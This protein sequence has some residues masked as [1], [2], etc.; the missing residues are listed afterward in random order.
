MQQQWFSSCEA[1]QSTD[2]EG[3][4]ANACASKYRH[5]NAAQK[6][7]GAME[8]AELESKLTF[9]FSNG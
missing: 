2:R 7:Y 5:L 9:A 4:Y 3:S 6:A 8:A 1:A